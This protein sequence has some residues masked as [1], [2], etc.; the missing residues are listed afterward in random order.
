MKLNLMAAL[1]AVLAFSPLM[2]APATDKGK[3]APAA[4]SSEVTPEQL[5][6]RK[7]VKTKPSYTKYVDAKNL[8]EKSGFPLI[9]VVLPDTPNVAFLKKVLTRKEFVK[10][11]VSQNCVLVFM[12]VKLDSKNPKKIDV[13]PLKEVELKFLENH[14]V[15]DRAIHQAKQ[16]NKEEP[17]FSDTSCYPLIICMDSAG[18][19]E[20]FRMGAYDKEGG[21]G[22]WLSTV[23]DSF[24]S[25]G[26]EPVISPLVQKIIDNPDD[27]KWK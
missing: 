14:V 7:L 21:F 19:K 13:K 16:Q 4:D 27:K 22:V 6:F 25:A 8:A 9:V 15:S 17:K 12:K 1:T 26:I 2:A 11:F 5:K 23:V 18:Q 20:L 24:K 10:E 3:D